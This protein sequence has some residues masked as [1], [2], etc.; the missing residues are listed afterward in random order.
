M[1]RKKWLLVFASLC[2]LGGSCFLPAQERE[3]NKEVLA[4]QNAIAREKLT[5][6]AGETSLSRLSATERRRRLGG[7]LA[8]IVPRIASQERATAAL[9]AALDWRDHNGNW[10]TAIKDQG[11][12]GGCWAFAAT[13]VL[14]SMVKIS[15]NMSEDID[16]SEQT[17]I[18]CSGA[19]DCED[20]G[21][22][23][24]AAEYIRTT[25]IPHE[26]CFPYSASDE[27]CNPCS[28]WQARVIKIRAWDWVSTSVTGIETA[29]QNGPLSTYMTVY[30]DF[31]HYRSGIYQVSSGATE[32]GGH[33]VTI[34]GYDH[35]GGYWICKNS[36]GSGWGETGFFRIQMGQADI[37]IQNLSM[38]E[39]IMDDHAPIFQ[40]INEHSVEE[41]E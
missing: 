28:G 15:E 21:Y 14:E 9:P 25:G 20:G 22:D 5:W 10:I 36:W 12:C 26:S 3:E 13:A 41:G 19:G 34:I 16:L 18:S 37:G 35:P 11:D 6:Q 27:L 8:R 17:L 32:E 1:I 24:L 38:S 29:L 40:A 4:V 31:Y 7:R 23:Y 39:P 30:S 2:V 33:L